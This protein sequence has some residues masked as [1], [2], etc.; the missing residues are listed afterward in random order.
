MYVRA[1]LNP[2]GR[3]QDRK[4]GNEQGFLY[5]SRFRSN[6]VRAG[7]EVVDCP[8]VASKKNAADI[9]IVVD[10]MDVI[11]RPFRGEE[12]VIASGD[13]D[14]TPLL[15]KIRSADRRI[16]ILT[17]GAIRMAPWIASSEAAEKSTGTITCR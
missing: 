16:V 9:R 14:F 4:N 8:S 12:I 15:H 3:V 10:V 17:A 11:G 2:S 13:S 1:Y 5:L 7:F 6:L